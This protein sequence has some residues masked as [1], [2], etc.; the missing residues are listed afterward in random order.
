MV[1]ALHIDLPSFL[2]EANE[3]V[4]ILPDL[5]ER[6]RFVIRVA[7]LNIQQGG[8]PFAA[9]VFERESGRLV[10]AGANR[11]IASRCSSA[12]AEVLALSL[13]QCRLGD[14]DLGAAGHPAHELVT[15]AEPCVMCIGAVLWSGVRHLVC[16]ARDE[17]ARAVGFD[18][19]P[20]HPEWADELRVRGI[21]VQ[22][23]VVRDEA[24]A[25]LK[26]YAAQGGLVYNA[27][28]G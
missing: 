18:E 26:D 27:R 22:R 28:C 3:T 12:H 6:M 5:T 21:S 4:T 1:E 24:A 25:I 16:G 20:K 15:S 17:D 11:V 23:D 13:A 10:A 19:G 2:R 7:R 14:Y 8:G 9:A